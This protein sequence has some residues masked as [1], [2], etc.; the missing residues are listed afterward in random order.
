MCC[1]HMCVVARV[2]FVCNNLNG[3]SS[4]AMLILSTVTAISAI[5]TSPIEVAP[6]F[7]RSRGPL[8]THRAIYTPS[9]VAGAEE[10]AAVGMMVSNA[11]G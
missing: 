1:T 10:G 3:N 9:Q 11:E 6:E 5:A 2:V 7:V 4:M 8:Y